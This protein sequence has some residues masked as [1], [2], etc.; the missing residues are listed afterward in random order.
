MVDAFENN[1][2]HLRPGRWQVGPY[3]EQL[4]AGIMKPGFLQQPCTVTVHDWGTDDSGNRVYYMNGIR[5][6]S[7]KIA[8]PPAAE[9][10][11][12]TVASL[13]SYFPANFFETRP[14][15]CQ[16]R[17]ID[18]DGM[19]AQVV[20]FLLHVVNCEKRY[21]FNHIVD[22]RQRAMA[23][24]L[25]TS[26]AY[27]PS[28]LRCTS[29]DEETDTKAVLMM[30]KV[31]DIR[32]RELPRGEMKDVY[33][34]R[35]TAG[36]LLDTSNDDIVAMEQIGYVVVMK[37]NTT[38]KY[39]KTSGTLISFQEGKEG[40]AYDDVRRRIRDPTDRI[41]RRGVS[42]LL[43]QLIHA[44]TE[45]ASAVDYYIESVVTRLKQE[46]DATPD[47]LD[48]IRIARRIAVR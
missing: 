2:E 32:S 19:N 23:L 38:S 15:G 18:A 27:Q 4:V 29:A 40:D 41:C 31:P 21:V 45:S 10:S 5:Q 36:G 30:T 26:A 9:C 13:L 33:E 3:Y 43:T 39:N 34:R 28:G 1:H 6:A 7:D 48:L 24:E 47:D 11:F 17:W 25:E 37:N 16:V 20:Q 42:Y 44:S 14:A 35:V 46:L 22:L 8:P 12:T